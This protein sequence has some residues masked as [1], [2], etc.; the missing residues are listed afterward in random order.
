MD[1]AGRSRIQ[2]PVA[3]RVSNLFVVFF[4]PGRNDPKFHELKARIGP[5]FDSLLGEPMRSLVREFAES[6]LHLQLAK[7]TDLPPLPIG[8]LRH[9]GL[10]EVEERKLEASSL[11]V[12]IEAE[13]RNRPPR[14][15]FWTALAAAH[16]CARILRGT[17][18]DPAA[19]RVL[20]PGVG[21]VQLTSDGVIALARHIVVPFSV[22]DR[23]LGWM[24]TSGM[25]KFGLID[26]EVRDVPPNLQSLGY[27]VN[28]VAQ[29]ILD[30]LDGSGP[31]GE[32]EV[33]ELPSSLR[34]GP[35]DLARASAGND[36]AGDVVLGL[37]LSIPEAPKQPQFLRLVRPLGVRVAHGAWL[38][39]TLERFSGTQPSVLDAETSSDAM[40][41]AHWRAVAD[42]PRVKN[43]F[44]R[45]LRPGENLYV[46]HGFPAG[47]RGKEYMW[48]VVNRWTGTELQGQ[49][50]NNARDSKLRAGH[51]VHL[52]ESEVFDWMLQ[53]PH[54]EHEGGY[55]T[56]VLLG[57]SEP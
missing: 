35:Q 48:V 55:T 23:G 33:L 53:L 34:I 45:G 11:A 28:A 6:G 36:A 7:R 41:A 38:F 51:E 37:E 30:V 47:L 3:D 13:D 50:V 32:T 57:A 56:E 1:A 16:A 40:Q 15:G 2:I 31:G 24:T 52:S 17:I 26:L 10:G 4:A 22:D 44:V 21:S 46:K 8:L 12:M 29:R 19:D 18:F 43:R 5:L 9:M 42:L 14:A 39:D 27:L 49:L 25:A 54:G 20:P